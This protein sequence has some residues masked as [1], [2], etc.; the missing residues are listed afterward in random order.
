MSKC[1][2]HWKQS[3]TFATQNR[4][5]YY[6][7]AALCDDLHLWRKKL[8]TFSGQYFWHARKSIPWKR[9]WPKFLTHTCQMVMCRFSFRSDYELEKFDHQIIVFLPQKATETLKFLKTFSKPGF[10]FKNIRVHSKKDGFCKRSKGGNSA[11]K[12]A[13]KYLFFL[14]LFFRLN[15]QAFQ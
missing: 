9:S 4:V 10:Y 13:L 11:S 1:I 8:S 2:S 15:F 6:H 12:C 3:L 7:L 5:R 14:H